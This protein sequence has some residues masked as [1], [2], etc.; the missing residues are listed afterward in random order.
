M[1][2]PWSSVTGAALVLMVLPHVL[3]GV[4]YDWLLVGYV[5]KEVDSCQLSGCLLAFFFESFWSNA[6]ALG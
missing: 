5:G 2:Y 6:P 4:W 1:P 3:W